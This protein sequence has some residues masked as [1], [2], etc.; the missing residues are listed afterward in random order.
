METRS[1]PKLAWAINLMCKLLGA[2]AYGM[3]RRRTMQERGATAAGSKRTWGVGNAE[4]E[5]NARE[6]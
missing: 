4:Q 2:R 5:K 1:W 6:A 3:M